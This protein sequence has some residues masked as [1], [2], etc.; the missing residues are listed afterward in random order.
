MFLG[1]SPLWVSGRSAS[2]F[3]LMVDDW[4]E[5]DAQATAVARLVEDAEAARGQ[6]GA[7]VDATTPAVRRDLVVTKSAL[8]P[9]ARTASAFHATRHSLD[10]STSG[11][12]RYSFR[13][14]AVVSAAAPRAPARLPSRSATRTMTILVEEDG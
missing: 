2:E 1:R 14:I 12:A 11:T 5:T 9:R 6:V 13:L 3:R 4:C 7:V 10:A 8:R